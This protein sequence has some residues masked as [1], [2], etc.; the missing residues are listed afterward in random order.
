MHETQQRLARTT[1]SYQLWELER[2]LHDRRKK[3]DARYDYRYSVLPFVF[4]DLILEGLLKEQD[5]RGLQEEKLAIIR[6]LARR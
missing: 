5:L 4:A 2:Y 3:I 1:E 6:D